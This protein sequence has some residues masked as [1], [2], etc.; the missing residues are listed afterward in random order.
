MD[1]QAYILVVDDNEMNRDLL[2]RRLK[3]QG[4]GV[5]TAENGVEALKCVASEQFDLILLDIMMPEMN[6]FEVLEHLKAN[7]DWRHIPV[8]VIS[9]AEDIDNM[10][11]GIQLGAEDYLPKPYNTLLLKARIGASLEK[12]RL[13]D[14]QQ[15]YLSELTTLQAMDRELNAT[16]DVQ[17]TMKITLDWALRQS[18][19]QAGFMGVL[20]DDGHI[21][22]ITSQGYPYELANESTNLIAPDELPAVQRALA[23]TDI[24]QVSPTNGSGLLSHVQSQIAV[25]ILRDTAVEAFLVMENTNPKVWNPDTIN[26]LDRLRD[27][28]VMAITNSKMYEAVQAA[29]LAKTEFVSFVSH[30]LKIP[31]T[32]IKGYADLLLSPSFGDPNEMQRK[33]LQTIRANVDR[34]ARLVS[35]LT[36]VSRIESGHLHLETTAVTLPEVI[37]DVIESTRAQ[38]DEKQQTL[39]VAVP[40]ELPRVWGDH[41]RLVQVLTNLVSNAYKYTQENGRI[42]IRAQIIQYQTDNHAQPMIQVS[43][44]DTGLGIKEEDQ[45]KIFGKFMRA[46]DNEALKSPGTGL[47]LNIT[48]SLIEMHGGHIWFESK[49]REGTTFHFALPVAKDQYSVIGNQ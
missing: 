20:D 42:T 8:I 3:R 14:A 7:D 25:P 40:D 30:E 39:T 36:D 21:Q 5:A 16:L 12:K 4:Y 38:I 27:H 34:M 37:E 9:A 15:I 22:V 18:Q 33:F 24:E 26:F 47:G 10:V 2:S 46:D 31:M 1:E 45:P 29:N 48:K 49:F 11:K 23:S 32:S 17:E 19:D 13:H 35:D 44:Q 6:G 43:I 41:Y 28:A